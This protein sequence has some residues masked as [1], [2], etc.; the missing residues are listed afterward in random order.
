MC[1]ICL[2][3]GAGARLGGLRT[4]SMLLH[5]TANCGGAPLPVPPSL[6][7]GGLLQRGAG[8]VH[9]SL[10]HG[11]SPLSCLASRQAPGYYISLIPPP[12]PQESKVRLR[13]FRRPRRARDGVVEGDG[14][15]AI[16]VW[17]IVHEAEEILTWRSGCGTFH[18]AAWN[19]SGPF[20]VL[21]H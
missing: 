20:L 14:V 10:W 21:I 8:L 12:P 11:G 18:R 4:L 5:G 2:V 19:P 13:P 15:V 16:A 17:R 7:Q 9:T 1:A 3:E 6:C